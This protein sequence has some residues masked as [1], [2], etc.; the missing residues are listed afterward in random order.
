MYWVSKH[1]ESALEAGKFEQI[2]KDELLSELK[3]FR[4]ESE[5]EETTPSRDIAVNIAG[6]SNPV[7]EQVTELETKNKET[8]PSRD[9]AGASNPVAEQVTEVSAMSEAQKTTKKNFLDISEEKKDRKFFLDLMQAECDRLEW[10]QENLQKN[11]KWTF[12]RKSGIKSLSNAELQQFCEHLAGLKP[13]SQIEKDRPG[14]QKEVEAIL[15][16]SP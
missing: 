14:L 4:P 15:Y 6:A 3:A 8:I 9:I 5:P 12:P 7:S 2:D 13:L 11:L 1:L 10:T 16:G